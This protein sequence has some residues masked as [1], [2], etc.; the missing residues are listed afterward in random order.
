MSKIIGLEGLTVEEVNKEITKGA[1]FVIFPYCFS[2]IILTFKRSS[3]IHFI[4]AGE[5]SLKKRLPFIFISF[6][7]GWWGIPWG[8][9]YTIQCLFTNLRGGNDITEQVISALR[10]T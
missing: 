8:I 3:D 6:F 1:K 10:Q 9:I 7:L 2:I 4:K 5:N